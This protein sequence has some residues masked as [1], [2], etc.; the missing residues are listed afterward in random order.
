[1]IKLGRL[2]GQCCA[3]ASADQLSR[4]TLDNQGWGYSLTGECQ[5]IDIWKFNIHR[6]PNITHQS[7]A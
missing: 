1:M 7:Q 5:V 4:F 2:T 3:H 6:F